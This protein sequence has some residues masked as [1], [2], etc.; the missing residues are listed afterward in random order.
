MDQ[1]RKRKRKRTKSGGEEGRKGLS[2]DPPPPNFSLYPAESSI[3]TQ[4]KSIINYFDSYNAGKHRLGWK[5]SKEES[6]KGRGLGGPGQRRQPL[7]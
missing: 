4:G 3:K 5:A 7:P 6:W 2:E 1:K